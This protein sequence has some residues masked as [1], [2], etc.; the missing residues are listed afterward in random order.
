[1]LKV[2]V[3][4]IEEESERKR[5]LL[6]PNEFKLADT[7]A[8][9]RIDFAMKFLLEVFIRIWLK[10]KPRT[11]T[12]A[13]RSKLIVLRIVQIFCECLLQIFQSKQRDGKRQQSYCQ[14]TVNSSKIVFTKYK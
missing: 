5:G 2:P 1:M 10:V 4:F 6:A 13:L 14:R 3:F 11:T 12:N 8:V 7:L 9:A